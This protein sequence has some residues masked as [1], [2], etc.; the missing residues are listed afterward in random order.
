MTSCALNWLQTIIL[1]L[2]NCWAT[3]AQS[4]WTKKIIVCNTLS[5]LGPF[6]ALVRGRFFSK[7]FW[8]GGSEF[9]GDLFLAPPVFPWGSPT[10]PQN[11]CPPAGGL[12][13]PDPPQTRAHACRPPCLTDPPWRKWR[14][15]VKAQRSHHGV[16]LHDGRLSIMPAALQ[17][18]VS[19][20][21]G[22][23]HVS[24][25]ATQRL[26]PFLMQEVIN[27]D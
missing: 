27:H 11:P 12:R 17:P 18:R 16:Y 1:T 25:A 2:Q 8:P 4:S 13:P 9:H 22:P 3:V 10:L 15:G 5:E 23:A 7:A 20:S 14:Q 19:A 24:A 26:V 21:K 6:F